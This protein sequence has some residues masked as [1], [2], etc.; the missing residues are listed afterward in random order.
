MVELRSAQPLW[1]RN[2]PATLSLPALDRTVE[3]DVAIVGGGITGGCTAWVL[4]D[5]GLDVALIEGISSSS[6]TATAP[7][8]RDASGS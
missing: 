4:A 3:A 5:A 7:Q 8:G 1:L 2:P 6:P